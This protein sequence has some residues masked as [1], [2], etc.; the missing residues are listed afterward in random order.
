LYV[1]TSQS[2]DRL[3]GVALT[4]TNRGQLGIYYQEKD[5][6]FVFCANLGF[7]HIFSRLLLDETAERDI[8]L[9]MVAEAD[10]IRCESSSLLLLTPQAHVSGG[11][12]QAGG[13]PPVWSVRQE[14]GEEG[15]GNF[16]L[17]KG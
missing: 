13:L 17:S 7:A 1:P 12:R 14:A 5:L 8:D 11:A 2:L 4:A 16:L 9:D 6:M 3:K 15:K 10:L